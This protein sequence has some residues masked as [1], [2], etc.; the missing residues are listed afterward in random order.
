[1]LKTIDLFAGIGGIRIGFE[2]TGFETVFSNDFEPT[3][4]TTYDLN[5]GTPKLDIEDIRT[6]DPES[7]PDFDFLLGGFP[8]QAFSVAG[9]RQGF[10][11]EKDRG[12][13]FFYIAKIL[14][15][16]QPQGFLLENVKNLVGHDNGNTF[17]VINSV[18][19]DLGY[20]FHYKVLNTMDYGNL[21]QNRERVYIVGFKNENYYN[22]FQFPNP[23]QLTRTVKEYLESNVDKKY[24]YNGKPLYDRIK[25]DV[26]D[27]NKIYQ[28]RR[29]YVRENKKNVC[30]TL[31]ANMGVG[32]HNVP[33]IKDSNGIRKLTP[34]ECIRLQGFP[35]TY[36]LPNIPD[37]A[38]YKQV[39]NS[40]SVPVIE[41]I[42][43][44]I[45][46]AVDS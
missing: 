2:N 30:P 15:A 20:K 8:C 40:V 43:K 23:T 38:L 32:G 33:I 12:N 13:L 41:A 14:E 35:E 17:K 31:T 29:K 26:T 9:H 28:W 34:L 36:T 39:G 18:L 46:V 7:I 3:C 19:T 27:E 1:M 25:D 21:P 24:Y 45:A 6:I 11:D 44:Q 10:G 16:K 5:F 4:K 22:N 42:A 37:Y